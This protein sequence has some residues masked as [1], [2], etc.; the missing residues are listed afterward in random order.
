MELRT[1]DLRY[2]LTSLVLDTGPTP[3]TDLRARL[4]ELGVDLGPDPR[5]RLH[6]ALRS[7]MRKGRLRRVAREVYDVGEIPRR[8]KTR[9]RH[10]ARVLEA[11]L[12]Q[13][14]RVPPPR[15]EW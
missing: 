7:E 13:G 5:R 3:T 4:V 1:Y 11:A 10:R 2:L 12:E 8:T 14:H 6:G 9:V 15:T